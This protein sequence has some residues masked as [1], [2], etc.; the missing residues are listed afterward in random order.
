MSLIPVRDWLSGLLL[1]ATALLS[2]AAPPQKTRTTPASTNVAGVSA[3]APLPYMR[4]SR[5]D[6]D[7]VALDIALRRFVSTKTP[8]TMIWLAGASH[9]GESN[10]YAALQMFLDAQPVVLFE[11]IGAGSKKLRPESPGDGGIQNTLASSL[12][13]S[14][15]LNA[16]D[17]D[18]PHFRNSD[19]TLAGLERLFAGGSFTNGGSGGGRRTDRSAEQFGELLGIMDGSSMLGMLLHAG[20]KFLGSTP[21]LRA[22]T[23]LILI[24]TLGELKSDIAQMKGAPPEIQKLLAVIIQERNKVVIDDLR[25]EISRAPPPASLAVFY[26]AGHMADFEKRLGSELGYRPAGEVWLRAMSVNTRQAGL[27]ESE[28]GAMRSLIQW[29]MRL[30]GGDEE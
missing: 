11:G 21:K 7:T 10:Y 19:L 18:R 14:F 17:Y 1:L 16:I 6:S 29:Q 27:S 30:I 25:K 2:S 5:L 15:Q 4:V 3:A 8:G 26:G 20:V 23:K 12:G 9:L 13:L 28:L 22:M 24:E